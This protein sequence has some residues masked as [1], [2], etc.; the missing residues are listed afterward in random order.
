MALFKSNCGQKWVPRGVLVDLEPRV[1]SE[2]CNNEGNA[3][4][5]DMDNV[6]QGP[7]G[8]GAGNNWA[9]GY[10]QAESVVEDIM[11]IIELETERADRLE[12]FAICHSILGG[13]QSII[14]QTFYFEI[15]NDLLTKFNN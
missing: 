10:N 9:T 14:F 6:Y 8:G 12:A 3:S 1:L 5:F 7:S 4:L 2:I 15:G 11:G 13:E